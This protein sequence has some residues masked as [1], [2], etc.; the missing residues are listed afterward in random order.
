MI[1]MTGGW[2][3]PVEARA[4]LFGVTEI[5]AKKNINFDDFGI[6]QYFTSNLSQLCRCCTADILN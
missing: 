5:K 6:L 4:F 2:R 3:A 1:V